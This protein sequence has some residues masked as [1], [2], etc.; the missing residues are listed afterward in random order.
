[1]LYDTDV[2]NTV[3]VEHADELG[4]QIA[5][6][7]RDSRNRTRLRV[8]LARLLARDTRPAA[9]PEPPLSETSRAR[10]AASST[11]RGSAGT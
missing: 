1:M 7:Q 9:T 2:R 8:R 11:P 4:R 3:A 10:V 6:A 5:A